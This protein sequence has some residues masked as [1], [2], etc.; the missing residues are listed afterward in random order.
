VRLRLRVRVRGA[1]LRV[2][3]AS[4]NFLRKKRAPSLQLVVL[5]ACAPVA[6]LAC[7]STSLA[8][9]KAITDQLAL[10]EAATVA[11]QVVITAIKF[12]DELCAVEGGREEYLDTI[13]AQHVKVQ[14]AVL[15]KEWSKLN[16][17]KVADSLEA[18]GYG[19][20]SL[21]GAA[22]GKDSLHVKLV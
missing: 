5:L 4:R 13:I 16:D 22:G 2:H 20:Q 19:L 15:H 3:A 14:L 7:A 10:D 1:S 12:G 11:N 17:E 8:M 21:P 6:L 18:M 9:N